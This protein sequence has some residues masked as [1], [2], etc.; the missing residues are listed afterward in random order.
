MSDLCIGT[1]GWVY[2]GWAG[3]FYP[4]RLS[5]PKKFAFY[6]SQFS[7]VE[8]NNTFYRLPT[9]K[10]V[11]G[12]HDQAPPGFLYAVK[13]S[14]FV[15]QVKKL[16]VE[17]VNLAL[18]LDRLQPLK[19]HLG[20]ILW[21]LPPNFGIN[22]ERLQR[23][24]A[25]LPRRFEHAIEFRHPSWMDRKVFKLL[26]EH[27]VA[28]ASVSSLR[29]PLNLTVT[30]NLVYIRFHGLEDGYAH[31]YTVQ[32]LKPWADHCRYALRHGLRVFAYFNNDLNTRAP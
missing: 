16:S 2:K 29:M 17:P 32:E 25:M 11:R 18:I 9:E 19:K 6:A 21:Q 27:N 30:G 7:T 22:V 20:P 12:W 1:S 3:T 24:L 5:P 8:I 10:A 13:G 28:H 15:T 31:D 26:N 14:R 4:P 23:F